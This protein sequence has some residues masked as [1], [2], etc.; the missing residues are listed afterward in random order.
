[1]NKESTLSQTY[2]NSVPKTELNRSEQWYKEEVK[3]S[4]TELL[5]WLMERKEN[6]K[7]TKK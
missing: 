4:N 6:D 3:K 7:R 2:T 1:M 5:N